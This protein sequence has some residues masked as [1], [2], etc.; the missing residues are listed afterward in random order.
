MEGL[1]AG[2][3]GMTIVGP[4]IGEGLAGSFKVKT[5]SPSSVRE[6]LG[7]RTI[8]MDDDEAPRAKRRFEKVSAKLEKFRISG[9]ED[10][11]IEK[12]DMETSDSEDDWD[13]DADCFGDDEASGAIV[14]EPNEDQPSEIQ[15]NDCLQ[16]YLDR[17][18]QSKCDNL[19]S[20]GAIRGDELVLWTPVPEI[21]NPFEDPSMKGRIEEV[22]DG[23]DN[24]CEAPTTDFI[25]ESADSDSET[26]MSA[27][28]DSPR[29]PEPKIE[30][31][32]DDDEDFVSMECD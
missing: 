18:K 4:E 30:E 21:R 19:P 2:T 8:E 7:K 31:I 10:E 13:D 9:E 24:S 12:G 3:S 22:N 20:R 17:M 23:E 14:Q 25:V 1:S 15:L 26:E 29:Y 32:N 11:C 27:Q 28:F 16:R 5:Q 6:W